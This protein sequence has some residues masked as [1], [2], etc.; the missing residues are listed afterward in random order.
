[1]AVTAT[2]KPVAMLFSVS[3]EEFNPDPSMYLTAGV[4]A[5]TLD[6]QQFAACTTVQYG[7]SLHPT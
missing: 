5:F 3:P 2:T 1:M 4:W 7:L 6:E